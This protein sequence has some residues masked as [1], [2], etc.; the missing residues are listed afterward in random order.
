MSFGER[1]KGVKAAGALLSHLA[2]EEKGNS[3]PAQ[4]AFSR[5]RSTR[6]DQHS[7][8]CEQNAMM[9]ITHI[10]WFLVIEQASI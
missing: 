7:A 8:V 5:P 4:L 6:C 9:N 3:I 1:S 10:K 2:P